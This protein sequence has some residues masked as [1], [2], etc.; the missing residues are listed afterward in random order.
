M[1]AERPRNKQVNAVSLGL[2]HSSAEP[3]IDSSHQFLVCNNETNFLH[4]AYHLHIGNG[5]VLLEMK[6]GWDQLGD[7]VNVCFLAE[8]Q[9]RLGTAGGKELPIARDLSYLGVGWLCEAQ[10]IDNFKF[11]VVESLLNNKAV[12]VILRDCRSEGNYRL[13]SGWQLRG[14]VDEE[15]VSL[16]NDVDGVVARMLER[17]GPAYYTVYLYISASLVGSHELLHSIP[18]CFILFPQYL[19]EVDDYNLVS[20]QPGHQSDAGGQRDTSLAHASMNNHH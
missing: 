8:D 11:K 2:R 19:I 10:T 12:L 9:L 20:L 15:P 18:R 6:S 5:D 3:V 14:V 17:L 4:V 7:L 1:A 16:I 13:E